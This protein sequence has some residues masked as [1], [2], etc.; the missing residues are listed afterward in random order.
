MA[1]E[2]RW[3]SKETFI[4]NPAVEGEG[5]EPKPQMDTDER[6]FRR[7][8]TNHLPGDSR[9]YSSPKLPVSGAAG[10]YPPGPSNRFLV[11]AGR[12]ELWTQDRAA[13]GSTSIHA[14]AALSI[15][16]CLCVSSPIDA[17]QAAAVAGSLW[18]TT[19]T[20]APT[21]ASRV[22]PWLNPCNQLAAPIGSPA[23]Q[24]ISASCTDWSRRI[25]SGNWLTQ[26][27][28]DLGSEAAQEVTML[29]TAAFWAA[30]AGRL[31][32]NWRHPPVPSVPTPPPAQRRRCFAP[33]R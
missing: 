1:Q 19:P 18:A 29:P 3:P 15:R 27:A 25:P 28:A 5:T 16:N 10:A 30:P 33:G 17:A 8:G 20:K 14:R 31:A 2:E 7:T 23:A 21:A 13:D 26:L 11:S 32:R 4:L 22:E 24:G 9:D 12:V 6:R